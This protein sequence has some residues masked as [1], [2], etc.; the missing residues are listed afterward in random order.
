MD[1]KDFANEALLAQNPVDLGSRCTVFMNS[2]VKQASKRRGVCR[3]YIGRTFIFCY[4]ECPSEGYK[5]KGSETAGREGNRSGRY[6][7]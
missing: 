1:V 2:K 7:L 6:V 3:G 5:D 4:K